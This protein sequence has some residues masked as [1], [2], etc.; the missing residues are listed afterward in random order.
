MKACR[1]AIIIPLLL[2]IERIVGKV[3]PRDVRHH[4]RSSDVW[5]REWITLA[6]PVIGQGHFSIGFCL[7]AE[8]IFR[9]GAR[10]LERFHLAT[11]TI[12]AVAG[13]EVAVKL[14]RTWQIV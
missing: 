9:E 3:F 10:S 7:I 13:A 11:F 6:Q 5:R 8:T 2:I 1:R 12:H 4:H 14:K